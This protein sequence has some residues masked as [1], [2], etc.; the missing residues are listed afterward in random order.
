MNNINIFDDFRLVNTNSSDATKILESNL[1]DLLKRRKTF[2]KFKAN[3]HVYSRI[4]YLLPSGNAVHYI[5]SRYKSKCE[6]CMNIPLCL[7]INQPFF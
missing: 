5:G 6:A 1:I 2:T 7:F 3:G 4:Y